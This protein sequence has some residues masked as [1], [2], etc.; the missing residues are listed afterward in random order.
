MKELDSAK[1]SSNTNTN[2]NTNAK[3]HMNSFRKEREESGV[4]VRMV[5]AH[6]PAT[7]SLGTA[8][9]APMKSSK[10][11]LKEKTI[12]RAI[13]AGKLFVHYELDRLK[14]RVEAAKKV[15]V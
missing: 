4:A 2:T 9:E 5:V 13:F 7:N 10:E 14:Q 6:P 1:A 8:S 11:G 12:E 3:D 15:C